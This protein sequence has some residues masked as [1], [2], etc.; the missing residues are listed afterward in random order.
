ML[1]ALVAVVVLLG[2]LSATAQRRGRPGARVRA[3]AKR[4]HRV[5]LNGHVF[6][7][8][9]GLRPVVQSGVPVFGLGF[10]ATHFNAVHGRRFRSFQP[11]FG[12]GALGRFEGR[13]GAGFGFSSFPFFP[14][15]GG[16]TTVV[17]VQQP[18]P[19]QF[20]PVQV[21]GQTPVITLDE[22]GGGEV[23]VAAGLPY[24]WN[25]LRVVESSYPRERA[26]LPLLTLLVLK[27]K[28]ILPA[29]DYWLEDG[30][31][32]YVTSTGRQDWVAVRD[33]DWEMT[34][35]LNTDRNVTFVL[36]GPR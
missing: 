20:V 1:P 35:Q 23:V 17:V 36:H 26:P 21:V 14:V 24:N 10:D 8:G 30:H 18:V 34:T 9:F 27:D 31:I 3:P 12:R 33:L 32:S 16:G 2:A 19:V 5:G 29:V 28:T 15:V 11:G 4:Q 22:S 13:R 6:V 7:P 25:R